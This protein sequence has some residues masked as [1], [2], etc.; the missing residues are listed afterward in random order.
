MQKHWQAFWLLGKEKVWTCS[1]SRSRTPRCGGEGMLEAAT[2]SS[3][4]PPPP[5]LVWVRPWPPAPWGTS[6]KV[7]RRQFMRGSWTKASI[8]AIT[9]SLFVRSTCITFSQVERKLPSIPLTSMAFSSMRVSRNG[10][11]NHTKS[12]PQFSSFTLKSTWKN[13]CGCFKVISYSATCDF[14]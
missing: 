3:M 10:T 7:K 9:L 11:C 13:T 2:A 4:L 8:I 1:N 5:P 6:G 14:K 12:S